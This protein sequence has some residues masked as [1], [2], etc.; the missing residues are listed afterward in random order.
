MPLAVGEKLGR[1][2]IVALLGAGGMGEVYL[3]RDTRLSRDVAIKTT[4]ARFSDRF[5]TE[6]RAIAQLNHRNVC[7]LY[8]VGPDYL[9]MERVEG[10]TLAARLERGRLDASEAIDIALQIAHGLNAAHER[11]VLHRD[12]KPANVMITGA[13]EVKIMDFGL[14]RLVGIEPAFDG[15]TVPMTAPG[16]V[17]GTPEYLAPEQIRGELTDERTDIW[18]FGV[19]LYEMLTGKRPFRSTRTRSLSRSILEDVPSSP[20]V[21]RPDLP[22]SLDAVVRKAIGKERSDRYQ[23]ARELIQDLQELRSERTAVRRPWVWAVAAVILMAAGTLLWLTL[24]SQ[25]QREFA[26]SVRPKLEQMTAFSDAAT[27][28]SISRDGKMLAFIRGPGVFVSTGQVYVKMLPNGEPIALTHDDARK[29]Q[30]EF[31]PD[32]SVVAYTVVNYRGSWDTWTV[33]VVRGAPRLWLPNASGLT[34]LSTGQVIFSEIK[35]G[36]HMTVAAANDNRTN[37][38]D[39]YDP[40]TVRGMAHLSRVSP[41]HLW[42]ALTEMDALATFRCKIARSEPCKR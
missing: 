6:G 12:L 40:P 8:D 35:T 2:E 42:I 26:G 15:E 29:L 1:Y 32:S 30:T 41:D 19:T 33:P 28:P 9:V 5:E 18:A 11:G 38:R 24:R 14:A 13:G 16:Q 37:E 4:H 7:T 23:N 21:I 17:I 10:E 27:W 20:S 36:V 34:W 3:A 39:V 25:S 31:A 22:P